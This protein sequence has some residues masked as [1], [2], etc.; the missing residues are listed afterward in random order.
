L[1]EDYC[2]DFGV[3]TLFF[4]FF[5]FSSLL[6]KERDDTIK[7][8]SFNVGTEGNGGWMMVG[9][10]DTWISPRLGYKQR[11]DVWNAN[12]SCRPNVYSMMRCFGFLP[13][14][15]DGNQAENEEQ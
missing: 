2:L 10:R 13:V 11:I 9:Y 6:R 1:E 7:N 15:T 4:F 3:L 12:L 8:E 14:V 5:F